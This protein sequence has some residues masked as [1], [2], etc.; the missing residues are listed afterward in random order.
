LFS[1]K[2]RAQLITPEIEARLYPFIGGIV[3]VGVAWILRGK[4]GGI[5]GKMAAQGDVKLAVTDPSSVPLEA[6]PE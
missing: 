4:G 5:R 2:H 3:A 6:P 1:T